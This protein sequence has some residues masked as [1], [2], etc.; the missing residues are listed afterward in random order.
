MEKYIGIPFRD[1]GR[2]WT[3]C[4]CFGLVR[5]VL[6]HEYGKEV[7]ALDWLSGK[8]L[9]DQKNAIENGREL[10]PNEPIID[11]YQPG[12]IALIRI[13]GVPCHVGV[14]IDKNRIMQI[15][16]KSGVYIQ[17]IEY[18]KR[19]GRLEGVYRVR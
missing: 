6:I 12:D 17:N 15:D 13:G 5:L 14:F 4:D 18:V 8:T 19:E 11:D 7:S 10:I 3:G 16:K 9:E 2:D 1:G